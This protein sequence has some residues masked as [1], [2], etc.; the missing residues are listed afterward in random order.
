VEDH[1]LL[2]ARREFEAWSSLEPALRLERIS[3]CADPEVRA[4]MLGWLAPEARTVPGRHEPAGSG[5]AP[6][7]GQSLG[8]YRLDGVLGEGGMGL[9]FAATD[10]RDGREVAIKRVRPGLATPTLMRRLAREF[11]MMQRVDHPG[12][13]RPLALETDADGAPYLVLERVHGLAFSEAELERTPRER[14]QLIARAAALAGVAH[15]QGIVHRDIKPSNLMISADGG[16]YLLDFGIA[17]PVADEAM[18]ALTQTGERMLTPRYAAPEQFRGETIGASADVFALGTML[19]DS[20]FGIDATVP[21]ATGLPAREAQWL[22]AIIARARD[23]RPEH[24]YRDAAELAADLERWLDSRRPRAAAW[25]QRLRLRQ[26]RAALVAAVLI[27]AMAVLAAQQWQQGRRLAPIDAGLGLQ[28]ADL[29]GL[30]ASAREAVRLALEADAASDRERA[31]SLMQAAAAEHPEHALPAFYLAMWERG[32]E[33]GRELDRLD[34]LLSSKRHL[35]L[36]L[37]RDWLASE[38]RS[39]QQTEHVL[40]AALDLRPSAWR[41][42]LALA[43]Q[44]LMRGDNAAARRELA[45]IDARE[46]DAK[47]AT[48]VLSDRAMLGDVG[49]VHDELPALAD[50]DAL[51]ADAVGAVLALSESRCGDVVGRSDALMNRADAAH[52]PDLSRRFAMTDLLCRGQLGQWPALLER[53]R[54]FLRTD[55]EA[56]DRSL[57]TAAAILGAIAAARL[58]DPDEAARLLASVDGSAT[59][60]GF[61]LDI[62]LARRML[63]LADTGLT[64]LRDEATASDDPALSALVRAFIAHGEGDRQAARQAL[65][66][67]RRDG[68]RESLFK[69]HSEWLG[70]ELGEARPDDP[71]RLP[72]LWYPPTSR[73]AARW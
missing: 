70:R 38:G 16:V 19:L 36:S 13:V 15:A 32:H 57:A 51:A 71:A 61:R 42:R 41:L 40:R 33:D 12:I 53:S 20:V 45:A 7:A 52:R 64:A 25:W 8:P 55:P 47:R 31:R 21:M 49:P 18:T 27:L 73:W 3:A 24:R 72:M 58:G 37:L 4:L 10:C 9:V 11:E 5:R 67:A 65:A 6:W 17:K 68:I 39:P 29:D 69:L 48:I 56:L 62:A 46:L 44:G 35:Y 2:A 54:L 43:H 59:A 63:G 60:P 26:R 50:R 30:P 23:P 28:V 34:A 14:V 22:Q 1:R 66:D